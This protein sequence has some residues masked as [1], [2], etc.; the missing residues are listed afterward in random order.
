MGQTGKKRKSGKGIVPPNQG[1]VYDFGELQVVL[2]VT[3]D[4]VSQ[5]NKITSAKCRF[6][7]FFFFLCKLFPYYLMLLKQDFF[8]LYLFCPNHDPRLMLIKDTL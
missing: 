4:S 6:V 1:H 2:R 5:N 3:T 7:S 8:P